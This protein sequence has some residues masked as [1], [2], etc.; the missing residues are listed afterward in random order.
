MRLSPDPVGDSA[1]G[2]TE[3]VASISAPARRIRVLVAEDMHMIRAA[4][5]ALLSLEDDLEVVADLDRGDAI[6]EAAL[7]TQ[8]D[9]VVIDI[10]LSGLDGLSAARLLHFR[11]PTCGVLILTGLT[12]PAFVLRALRAHA[13]GFIL[14]DAP[15]ASLADAVRTVADGQLAIAPDLLA[16]AFETGD[17][18]LTKREMEVLEASESGLPTEKIGDLLSLSPTTV[19]NYI[20]N[21]IAKVGGRNRLE[22]IRIARE[23]GWIMTTA[24]ANWASHRAATR[25]PLSSDRLL[26]ARQL[27]AFALD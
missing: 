22:A 12:Q 21:A 18:P 9:V 13:K 26:R 1:A 27:R 5:V 8:P 19:R 25:R 10:C 14:K 6:V 11:L 2:G 23:A 17:C 16:R 20:S 3:L 15:P 4:L 7:R 24:E